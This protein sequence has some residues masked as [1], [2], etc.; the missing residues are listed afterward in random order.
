ML[1]FN[2]LPARCVAAVVASIGLLAG[3]RAKPAETRRASSAETAALVKAAER[4]AHF[5]AVNAQLEL[6]G[7]IYGYVD[8]DG[9]MAK[10][11]ATLRRI[12]MDASASQPMARAFVPDD[13]APIFADLGLDDI[14]AVGF[15]SVASEEGGFRNRVF[16][17][18]PEG[19]RG[20]LAGL[21]GK[22]APFVAAQLA[23]VDADLV[24]ETDLDA[25]AVYAAIRAAVERAV[26]E[27]FARLLDAK[28]DD[29]SSGAP[30]TLRDVLNAA[31]G[32]FSLV[33][34]VDEARTFAFGNGG[35]EI[36]AFDLALRHEHGGEKLA[37][38]L[39]DKSWV[40]REDRDGGVTAFVLTQPL[41]GTDWSPEV[42]IKGDTFLVVSKKAF[43]AED[44]VKLA[45]HPAFAEALA[46]VGDTG[47]G[48]TYVGPHLATRV[49]RIVELNPAMDPAR[50]M[51]VQR[52]ISALPEAGAVLVSTRQNLPDGI[53][54][55]SKWNSSLKSELAMANP[56]ILVPVGLVSAMAVPA[57]Q[58]VRV[59]P[60]EKAVMNN[61]RQL[62]AA[63]D[64]HL[65]RSRGAGR[66][67]PGAEIDRG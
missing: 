54:I 7:T 17:H 4:S 20:L 42:Q 9:D 27:P 18:T 32:R 57:F 58:S 23:P 33:L 53:L 34:R 3:C 35:L 28:L 61:L 64:Q 13:L 11:A 43:L 44:D 2:M 48:L 49:G 1:S 21:G 24:G 29:S 41:A 36:P 14:K 52:L 40:K 15:S 46:I 16:F 62:A 47:N 63:R 31:R 25:P 26:G 19:R 51:V 10:L 56:G 5:A 59:A 6:G 55:R 30:L 38:V 12:A 8:I 50:A 37:G 66:L 65:L 45:D 22:P 39:A 67:H 60:Q